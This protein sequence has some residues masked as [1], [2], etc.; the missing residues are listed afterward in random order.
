MNEDIVVLIPVYDPN[1]EIMDKFIKKLSK[2]FKNIVFVN[3]GSG[4]HHDKFM[5]SIEKKYPMIKHYINFGKGRGLKN[6]INYILNNYPA[7]SVIV[8]AD[9]DG[10]HSVKD[11]KK[12][13][14]AA[15]K[16]QDSLV[17]G[18]R[19]FSEDSVPT[20]S[21]FGNIITKNVLYSFV[22]S[23]VSDTQTGLRA[24]SYSVAKNFLATDGERYEYETNVLI[25]AKEKNIPIC[26]VVIDTIYI[27][28]NETSHFNP[29]KDSVRIYK[30]FASFILVVF[31]SYLV[32]TII[33]IKGIS[34]SSNIFIVPLFIFLA[35]FVSCIIKLLFNNHVNLKYII[36]NYLVTSCI[37]MFVPKK[38]MIKVIIDLVMF[39]ISL[40][41]VNFKTEKYE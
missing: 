9:C 36:I 7:S 20:R 28:E 17:L 21:R 23:K 3:D 34:I 41:V 15:L 8:T 6:G 26:E 39:I 24:A 27:N 37:L 5:N 32:E 12:V 4:K 19:D 38:V 29:I 16:N 18:V 10:Q 33:F 31:I 25:E 22:G 30:L 2:S 13:G 40:V 35:K 1:E 11:I 14:L